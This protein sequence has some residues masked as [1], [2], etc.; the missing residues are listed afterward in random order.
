MVIM[1]PKFG[2]QIITAKGKVYKFDDVLCMGRFLKSGA[3][4]EKETRQTVVTSF[5]NPDEFLD[6]NETFFVVS[7]EV[8]SPMRGN[9]AAFAR[10]D[11]ADKFNEGKAGV[12]MGWKE[13]YYK[14]Q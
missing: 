14:V 5:T 13:Y 3:Q 1:D 8:K 9:A 4:D 2:S 6:I 11:A 7:P 10:Q 12:V